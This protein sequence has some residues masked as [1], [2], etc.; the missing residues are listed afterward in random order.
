MKRLA[1]LFSLIFATILMQGCATTASIQG[2]TTQK[3]V[4]A[5]NGALVNKVAVAPA[6]GGKKTNPLWTSQVS[7][8]NFEA[9]LKDSLRAAHLLAG[10]QGQYSLQADLLSLQQ[11]MFGLDMTVTATV[12]YVVTDTQSGQAVFEE[13]LTTPY[14]A[15]VGDAFV[16]TKRLQ[17]ANEGAIRSSIEA[18]IAKLDKLNLDKVSLR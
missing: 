14:T 12:K 16:G 2:M 9:A 13:T 11:P 1:V 8:E 17:L 15:T 5:H 18:L 10:D 4:T 3:A 6:S 7:S